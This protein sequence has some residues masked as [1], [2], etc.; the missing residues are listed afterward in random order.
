M[1]AP[2]AGPVLP[3]PVTPVT[4][5]TPAT[6]E[7]SPVQN[8]VETAPTEPDWRLRFELDDLALVRE[9]FAAHI[10][11]VRARTPEVRTLLNRIEGPPHA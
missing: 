5:V 3:E 6:S 1:S 2:I 9:V 7:A 11:R 4:P 10:A 8:P